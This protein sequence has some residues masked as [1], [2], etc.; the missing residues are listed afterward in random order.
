MKYILKHLF[1]IATTENSPPSSKI[2]DMIRDKVSKNTGSSSYSGEKVDLIFTKQQC[3][4]KGHTADQFDAV[5]KD[6][7]K[8]GLWFVNTA[9]TTINFVWILFLSAEA[10]VTFLFRVMNNAYYL[11]KLNGEFC[12]DTKTLSLNIFK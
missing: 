1:Y 8:L 2:Y 11:D 10:K 7:E 5:V 3:L 6:Y 4:A 12:Y 9:N